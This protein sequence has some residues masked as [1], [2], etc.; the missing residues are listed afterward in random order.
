MKFT[1]FYDGK[2]LSK[3]SGGNA[4]HI[5]GIRRA[6]HLQLVQ[7]WQKFPGLSG[8]KAWRSDFDNEPRQADGVARIVPSTEQEQISDIIADRY[9]EARFRFLPLV[10]KELNLHCTLNITIL[11]HDI[12]G[13]RLHF[14]DLDNRLKTIVDALRKPSGS[15]E[16]EKIPKPEEN[17]NPFYV[18]LEDDRLVS[19]FSVK[20]DRLLSSVG[21]SE[22]AQLV[23]MLVEVEAKPTQVTMRNLGLG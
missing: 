21:R 8:A 18:L 13:Q 12:G 11:G 1:L 5:H 20:T 10:C 17:E 22:D 3:Q 19:G 23:R 2:L 9:T 6:F 15:H 16:F 14:G 7:L 4:V